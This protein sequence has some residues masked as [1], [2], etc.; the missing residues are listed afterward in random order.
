ME[1]AAPDSMFVQ[2]QRFMA[3][4][5]VDRRIVKPMVYDSWVRSRAYGVRH[6]RRP[7]GRVDDARLAELLAAN[8]EFI[9]SSKVIMAKL[10]T[11]VEDANSV[12]SLTDSQGVVLH[13][14]V[15]T[16]RGH[17][18]PGHMP[19]FI[20]SERICGTNGIGT[21][22]H[23]AA[24]VELV[25]AE[26]YCA[27]DHVWYCS[28][29]PI[30][31]SKANLLGVFNISISRE[32]FHHH[33][34][35]MV[36]AAAHA[37]TEQVCLRELLSEQAAIMELLDEGLIVVNHEGLLKSISQK[38]CAILGI[39]SPQGSVHISQIIPAADMLHTALNRQVGFHDQEVLLDLPQGTTSCLIS[40]APTPQKGVVFTLREGKR[41]RE[42]AT[43]AL[44]AKATYTFDRIIGESDL[45]KETIRQGKL[46]AHSDI[47]TLIIG[48][49]GTGKELFAQAI[50]NASSRA[51]QPFVVVNCGAL[52]RNLVQS[53]LFGYDEGAF[54][55]A[56]TTRRGYF[57]QANGGTL[58]LDE[59]G[60]M[61]Q[62][63]Q[64]HLLRVLESRYVTRVGDHRPIPVDVRVIA[65][66]QTDLM[67]KVREG[68]FRKDLWF[69]LAVLTIV[70]P[71]L[72][73]RKADI[74]ALVRHFLRTKAAQFEMEVPDVPAPELE[75]LYSHD[76]P[77]N[78]RELEFVIERSLL[79]S[80]SKAVGTPLKFEFAPE[81][82]GGA[83]SPEDGW[84][85]LAELEQRYIRRVLEKTGNKLMGPGSAT[86]L[87]GVHYTTLRAHMLKMGLPLPRRKE[88][89]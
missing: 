35:G 30:F 62:E 80:R 28:A 26:H 24:P 81:V 49:S 25:G 2:W 69:R 58:F 72:R 76:W 52:P 77:G 7:E 66:T 74:P 34:R 37:I 64:V 86:E 36:E 48:E 19:G 33:T 12:I 79:L 61:P 42:L 27:H 32:S 44:G 47:T 57:E 40:A 21:C 46:A 70:I 15:H 54:T 38:A 75:R 88:G 39:P 73:D 60:E 85:S 45:L 4:Q 82:E 84:P 59:I 41:M 56:H 16:N 6:D 14:H 23:C 5:E 51:N 53:E 63:A 71:P 8:S 78:V 43:R 31:D 87:L 67:K 9:E 65:A 10:F 68:T 83:A 1:N 50:H 55:G 3:G 20:F 13:T 89:R 22:L 18:L 17:R 29:A 11:A